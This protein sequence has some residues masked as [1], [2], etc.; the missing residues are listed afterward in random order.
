MIFFC[1]FWQAREG[2]AIVASEENE[3]PVIIGEE[4]DDQKYC[5]LFDRWTAP[6]IW[7]FAAVSVLFLVL[8]ETGLGCQ[9]KTLYCS[10]VSSRLLQAIFYTAHQLFLR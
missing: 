9:P 5:I 2:V 3:E 8:C 7:M 4:D 6:Q 1:A 10:Q